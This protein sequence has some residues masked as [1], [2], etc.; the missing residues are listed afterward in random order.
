MT[1]AASLLS[2]YCHNVMQFSL[3]Q[4]DDILEALRKPLTE[5]DQLLEFYKNISSVGH[6]FSKLKSQ[7]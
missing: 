3:M 4:E 2:N 5:D 6:A 1:H 7:M